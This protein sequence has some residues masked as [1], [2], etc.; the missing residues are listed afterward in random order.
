MVVIELT[1]DEALTLRNL[2]DVAV[3]AEGMR[4]AQF[5][6]NLDAKILA[7]ARANEAQQNA[8]AGNGSAE[9]RP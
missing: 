1:P 2:I 4:A 9:A 5:A 6:V 7:A 3:R 8:N